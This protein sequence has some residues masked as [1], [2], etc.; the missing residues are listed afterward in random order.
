VHIESAERYNNA[1][2]IIFIYLI[3]IHLRNGHQW[4]VTI[5]SEIIVTES[6]MIQSIEAY[7]GAVGVEQR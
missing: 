6:I 4:N 3:A 2:H 1:F 5:S 7:T